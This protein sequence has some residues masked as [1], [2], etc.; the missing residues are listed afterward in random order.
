[1]P[2]GNSPGWVLG[3]PLSG[4]GETSRGAVRSATSTAVVHAW[5]GLRA[6]ELQVAVLEAQEASLLSSLALVERRLDAGL[7]N[8]L[9]RAQAQDALAALRAQRPLLVQQRERLQHQLGVL[10][11]AWQALQRRER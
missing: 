2:A 8:T 3:S 1:M 9:E 5:Y 10:V 7:A 4:P 11:G 6:L